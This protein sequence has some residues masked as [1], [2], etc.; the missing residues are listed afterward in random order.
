MNTKTA[1]ISGML[2]IMVVGCFC[3]S[4]KAYALPTNPKEVLPP[5]EQNSVKKAETGLLEYKNSELDEIKGQILQYVKGIKNKEK[6]IEQLIQTIEKLSKEIEEVNISIAQTERNIKAIELDIIHFEELIKQEEATIKH[7]KMLIAQYVR[8]IYELEDVSVLQVALGKRMISDFLDDKESMEQIQKSI[9]ETVQEMKQ[10]KLTLEKA[11]RELEIKKQE[12]NDLRML[13]EVQKISL[14]EKSNQKSFLLD[15][16]KNEKIRFEKLLS[17]SQE[18]FTSLRK[19]IKLIGGSEALSFE[20]AL[21]YATFVENKTGVKRAFI[22][23]ILKQESNWG[24]NT[25]TSLYL[26]AL[27]RCVNRK[28]DEY[29]DRYEY[30]L[31]LAQKRENVFLQVI[32]E[33]NLPETMLVSAC[34]RS[35][36]GTGGAL[37]PAQFMP[38][39]WLGY[40]EQL[41]VLKGSVPSPFD[42]QDAMLAMGVK[43]AQAGANSQTE[44]AE[45][46]SAMI[47]FAG[48]NWDNP[49][50]SFYGDSVMNLAHAYQE[51]INKAQT[52]APTMRKQ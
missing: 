48:G 12:Q 9:N 4:L 27:S 47:Y 45:W 39:T 15:N 51:E 34:P 8:E 28:K 24:Q 49:K 26:D 1:K 29:R 5:K 31:T 46:K 35:Y 14:T 20:R 23:A 33:L 25:G 43:L 37:G 7:E 16:T 40:K 11:R 18:K 50:F 32:Q 19:E 21:E 38:D 36:L 3:F 41:T 2:T 17:E 22:L 52:V 42:I 30:A 6:E 44:E 10:R 13:Q